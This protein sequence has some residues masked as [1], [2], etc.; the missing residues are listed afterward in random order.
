MDATRENLIVL[1]L[2][3]LFAA[4]GAIVVGALSSETLRRQGLRQLV[5][6]WLGR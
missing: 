3:V 4:A 2:L 6:R 5:K 1:G